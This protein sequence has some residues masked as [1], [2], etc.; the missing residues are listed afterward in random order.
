PNAPAIAADVSRN[1]R[2]ETPVMEDDGSE[3]GVGMASASLRFGKHSLRSGKLTETVSP[4]TTAP[5]GPQSPHSGTECRRRPSISQRPFQ[6]G[7][8]NTRLSGLNSTRQP[9]W[10]VVRSA[11]TCACVSVRRKYTYPITSSGRWHQ[12]SN[13]V[14]TIGNF[15]GVPSIGRDSSEVTATNSRCDDLAIGP[16]TQAAT[17]AATGTAIAATSI[18]IAMHILTFAVNPLRMERLSVDDDPCCCNR[19][20]HTS[21]TRK[22]GTQNEDFSL[23]RRYAISPQQSSLARRASVECGHRCTA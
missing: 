12:A 11:S 3:S 1:R 20:I 14:T 9:A 4:R 17:P 22:R 2:R 21:P 8:S 6:Q 13:R 19:V 23:A 16:T 15:C 5:T 18:V 7:S 10:F